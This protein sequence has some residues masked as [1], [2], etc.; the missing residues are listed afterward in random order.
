[1]RKNLDRPGVS[2]FAVALAGL[3]C[4]LCVACSDGTQSLTMSPAKST[5]GAG[6]APT[7]GTGGL[8]I[9]IGDMGNGGATLGPSC[10]NATFSAELRPLTLYV[11]LDQSGSMKEDGD[12]WTPV[13]SAIRAFVNAA[14]SEGVR[15]ALQYFALGETDSAKCQ[16]DT[17]ALPEVNVQLPAGIAELEASIQAHDFPES[18][19]CTND[20]VH[21]G[22]PTRPAVEGATRWLG[23]WLSANPEQVGALLLATDGNPSDICADNRVEDVATALS[24]AASRGVST[25]VIGIA[26]EENLQELAEAGGTGAPPFIIDGS[27]ARTELE[28]LNALQAIRGSALACDYDIPEGP[29]SN[30]DL[31]NIQYSSGASNEPITL[32]RMS[33][34]EACDSAVAGWYYIETGNELRLQLCPQT[35]REVSTSAG[36]RVEIVVGCATRVF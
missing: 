5:G 19:C 20:N 36:G 14:E 32:L 17:Y 22:T 25:Y 29:A 2:P 11:L 13:T 28:F 7:F 33:G 24:E 31:V 8:A 30:H 27:G 10:A 4:V 26:H 16:A 6:N 35:C 21:S 15:V 9:V 34:A 3:G 1:M 12:R 23:Q 18:E